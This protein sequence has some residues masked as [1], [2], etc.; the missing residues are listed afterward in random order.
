M[1]GKPCRSM[2]TAGLDR[3]NVQHKMV[4]WVIE[5]NNQLSNSCRRTRSAQD[6]RRISYPNIQMR[7]GRIELC[8]V[9]AGYKDG[10]SLLFFFYK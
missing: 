6:V 2:R 3:A 8:G 10:N 1:A 7:E 9:L 5:D 4:V